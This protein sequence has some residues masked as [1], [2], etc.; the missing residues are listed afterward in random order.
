MLSLYVNTG[1]MLSLYVN[2]GI[3]LSLYVNT[4]IMSGVGLVPLP[5]QLSSPRFFVR[6]VLLN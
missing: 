1:I 3:M 4:G 5:E 6:F 2:T